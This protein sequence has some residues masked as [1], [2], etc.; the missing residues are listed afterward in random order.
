M[1]DLCLSKCEEINQLLKTITV[2]DNFFNLDPERPKG[3]EAFRQ[4]I[5]QHLETLTDEVRLRL[6]EEYFGGGP[7]KTLLDDESITE[8]IINRFD[9][10]WIERQGQLQS[11][12][13]TFLSEQT[14]Q[15]FLQRLYLEIGHEPTLTTPFVD[16]S[17]NGSRLHIIGPYSPEQSWVRMTIRKH[18]KTVWS[19]N[20]LQDRS[21]GSPDEMNYLRTMIKNR[22][23]FLVIG[24]T[25]SGKTSV[26]KAL[27]NE[28]P[29]QERVL[30]LEDSKEIDPPNPASTHL[31]TRS[32]ARNILTTISLTDLV[33]QSLRMRPDRIVVG[34]V[35]GGEAK[36]LLMALATGHEGSAGTLHAADAGQA[37]IRLEMLIQMGASHWNLHAIR[38]LI[39]LSI[40]HLI[41]C[42]RK[43]N[44]NRYLEGIYRLVSVEESGVIVERVYI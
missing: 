31:L 11:C 2:S 22:K 27:L 16:S 17:W 25:G 35:R 13:D 9:S 39:H 21:W 7:L 12:D 37:L 3:F 44:G 19:L 28:C 15:N 41:V 36:D 26:L 23:N 20:A 34:E 29:Q 42:S 18:K 33:K 43:A 1:N 10:V 8:I 38:R 14:Y 4:I 6:N 24:P 32:D 40:D 30:I 5:H